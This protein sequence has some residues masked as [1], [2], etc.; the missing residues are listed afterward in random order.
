MPIVHPFPQ[1]ALG[2]GTR[3][4]RENE[5]LTVREGCNAKKDLY[6]AIFVVN[7]GMDDAVNAL[8]RLNV[9]DFN[10]YYKREV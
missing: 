9:E 8:E 7:R 10:P 4:D 6:K 3:F 1:S 5:C 2:G